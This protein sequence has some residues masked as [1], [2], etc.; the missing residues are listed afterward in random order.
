MSKRCRGCRIGEIVRGDVN[1]LDRRDRALVR[2]GNTL[3]KVT[4]ISRQS[5]LIANRRRDTTKKRG[6]FGTRLCKAEDIIDEEQHI[7]AFFV[8]EIFGQRQTAEADTRT[9][10]GRLVHLSIDQRRFRFAIG[11]DNAGFHHFM[12]EIITFAR[13]LANAGEYRVPA[14][15]LRDVV[16]QFHDQNGLADTGTT[17]QAD[18]AATRIRGKQID[19]L[20]TGYKNVGFG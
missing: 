7:L 6:H 13:S 15:R 18:L 16:D 2:C 3:L 17:E 5:R 10:A 19:N 14:M 8:T 4:H 1:R 9:R 11:L 12:I 20:N